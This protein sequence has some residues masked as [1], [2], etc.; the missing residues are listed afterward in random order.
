M[1]TPPSKKLMD[2]ANKTSEDQ[3]VVIRDLKHLLQLI[4][5][6][7]DGYQHAAEITKTPALH[8]LFLKFEAERKAFANELKEHI[9]F[10]G[11]HAGN[12]DGGILGGLHRTW[13]TIKEAITGHDDA[14]LLEA[15][16]KGEQA[17]IK[18]FDTCI[19]DF[20][21]HADHLK[22]LIR[23]RDGIR[24]ALAEIEAL[25]NKV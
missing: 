2:T 4:N 24:K 16:A 19:M 9:A 20:K 6:G 17:A 7:K 22:L 8:Q 1:L 3:N 12:E 10:H 21:D 15:I 23:Q 18:K 14:E 5:D 11:G 25:K 13:I